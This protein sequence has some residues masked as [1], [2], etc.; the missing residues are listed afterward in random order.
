MKNDLYTE[1]DFVQVTDAGGTV[2]E[3]P[4]PKKWLGTD[5]V[6]PGTKEATGDSGSSKEPTVKEVLADVGDDQ[7]KAAEALATEQAKGDD[8]RG[9]LVAKLEAI[10]NPPQS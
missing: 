3:H 1:D 9:T 7:D 2:Q 8:A 5:L 4:V 6:A 10:V